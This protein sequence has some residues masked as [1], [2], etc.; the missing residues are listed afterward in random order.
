[1]Q[2]ALLQGLS[3]TGVTAFQL[4]KGMDTGPILLQAPTTIEPD[5]NAGRLLKRLTDIGIS[6]LLELLPSIAAGIAK[7]MPQNDSN[8]TF[9]PKISR[10]HAQIDWNQSAKDIQQLALA[11]NPEPMAWTTISEE[12][13]RILDARASSGLNLDAASGTVQLVG[14]KVL[15]ACGNG[16]LQLISVQPAGKTEMNATDWFRG[17]QNKESLVLGT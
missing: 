4:D 13:L 12:S 14:D 1:V 16:A 3:A 11:M 15:V 2:H 9:A 17:A 7:P 6:V 5:E 10:V 8:A